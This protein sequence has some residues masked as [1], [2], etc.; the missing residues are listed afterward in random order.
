MI[1]I[2]C[3]NVGLLPRQLP[4][5]PI[6]LRLCQSCRNERRIEIFY[7]I[8]VLT[9]WGSEESVEAQAEGLEQ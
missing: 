7:S 1:E 5:P 6:S 8:K 3:P 4:I 2:E 9:D